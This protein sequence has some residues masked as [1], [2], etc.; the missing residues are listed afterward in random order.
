MQPTHERGDA[1]R[2]PVNETG[3]KEG[4]G[5]GGEGRGEERRGESGEGGW[6]GRGLRGGEGEE[7][8]EEGGEGRGVER[9]KRREEGRGGVIFK[10]IY[11]EKCY[12]PSSPV[13]SVS[14]S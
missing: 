1:E 7:R 12:K 11:E 4:E 10:W 9:E 2:P 14:P 6:E 8:R 13:A 3:N 5:W